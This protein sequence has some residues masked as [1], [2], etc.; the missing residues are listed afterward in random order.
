MKEIKDFAIWY[1]HCV[2]KYIR[3]ELPRERIKTHPNQILDNHEVM[4]KPFIKIIDDPELIILYNEIVDNFDKMLRGKSLLRILT[5]HISYKGRR[6]KHRH[7]ALL[8]QVGAAPGPL[9]RA[10][11]QK[12][13][14][15]IS[16]GT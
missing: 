9:L 12:V 1:T 16:P 5:R 8:E 2:S 11:F 14:I 10:L 15:A 6:V 7:D 4:I 3:D 13:A